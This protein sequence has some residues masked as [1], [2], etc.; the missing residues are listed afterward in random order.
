MYGRP[1]RAR[2]PSLWRKLAAI[3]LSVVASLI[4][5][6]L[7]VANVLL[8]T[9]LLRDAISGSST[10]FGI[11]GKSSGLLV[12]YQSAYSLL[13]GRVHLKGVAIRGR[14]REVEWSLTLDRAEADIALLALV[15]RTFRA[16]HVRASGFTMRVRLRLT[17]AEAT[18]SVVAALPPIAGFADPPLREPGPEPP[19]LTD[20]DYNLWTLDFPD[21]DVAQVREVWIHTLRSQG[22]M[23]ANGRWFY[24]PERWLDVG[25]ATV[26][27]YGVDLSHG[28]EPLARGVRGSFRASVHPF[29]IQ[30]TSGLALLDQISYDG[31]LRGRAFV[32]GALRLLAPKSGVDFKRW[33]APFDARI[34]LE[35][36][37]LVAG[38]HART[39]PTDAL[40]ET[41][42]LAVVAPVRSEFG[43]DGGV[44][45]V[46]ARISGL[47]ISH[48]GR[49]RARVASIA[50]TLTSGQLRIAQGFED[51]RFVLDVGRA[52]TSDIGG[53]QDFLPTT[54]TIAVSSGLVS[55]EGH[56][57]GSI[58][59]MRGRAEL[60]ILAR[61]L[62]V[63]RGR[64]RFTA[65]IASHARVL[66]ASLPEGWGVGTLNIAADDV[67]LRL[68]RAAIT[69]K[70]AANVDRLRGTW[71]NKTLDL[72]GINVA[73]QSV[74][75]ASSRSDVPMLVVPSLKAAA[76]RLVLAP[77]G[78]DGR[79]SIDLPS[80]RLGDLARLRE[81]HPLPAGFRLE[82]GTARA[83][84]HV[85][86]DL[87][88]GSMRGESSITLRGLR[89][90]VGATTFFG[91]VAGTVKA[92]R[93]LSAEGATDFSG[94]TLAITRA[95][96][97]KPV[98]PEDAWWAKIALREATLRTSG[99]TRFDAKAHLT[100]KDATP[101]TV[102]V[103]QN[104]GVP[105]W[106]ANTFRMPILDADAE[107][108]LSPASLEVRSFVARGGGTSLR[109]EYAKRDERQDGAV[110]MDLGWIG[111]G[112]DLAEGSTGLVLIGPES[113]FRRKVASMRDAAAAANRKT[114]AA[115]QLSRYAAMMPAL[116]QSEASELA[117]RCALDVRTCDDAAIQNLLRTAAEP[118]ERGTLS[119]MLYAPLVVAAAKRGTDGARLDP[120]IVGS[121]AEALRLGGESTLANLRSTTRA[122]AGSEPDSAR[123]KLIAVTG[124]IESTQREDSYSIGTMTTDAESVYFVTPFPVPGP[125]TLARFRGVFV[126]R[127]ARPDPL[128]SE[129]PALVLVGAFQ[130]Q[131]LRGAN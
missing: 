105:T 14:D 97:G 120:L 20:A 1:V 118:G 93:V 69:G 127:Y 6:Y 99:H 42:G 7:L 32:A 15:H 78:A 96:T 87:T 25:P 79:V 49:E 8:R 92:R 107:V 122:V 75:V 101:A 110:L 131:D 84:V 21:V 17:S 16:T 54:R 111:L 128:G 62:S 88:S 98:R 81:L 48:L 95:S 9:R 65:N 13:P 59:E 39:E 4:V 74:A 52:E 70:L 91:D 11:S 117:A 77:G 66:D 57:D 89:A 53:W 61:R 116:R 126:Q 85:N 35:R 130:H 30:R 103:A 68:G 72:S 22:D 33:E 24:R 104:T 113:W 40:L 76:P 109:A 27:T 115:E 37:K 19:P 5:A 60:R 73:L 86:V 124:C 108:R 94:S 12:D 2:W 102:L 80:A 36:G 38:T 112:Y 41:Q 51:A 29:D 44:A 83:A 58:R 64:D 34:V 10:P 82:R 50:A 100:A 3:A 71:A 67:A 46:K 23:R 56:A 125:E 90:R 55:A 63:K 45:T 129:P 18:P 26:D 47:R 114:A 119:G 28:K 123:G 43:V 106:A 31:Q 121:L